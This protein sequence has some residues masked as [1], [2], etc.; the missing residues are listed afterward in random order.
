MPSH[1][2]IP[3]YN[4]KMAK[5]PVK[6]GKIIDL[7]KM[8]QKREDARWSAPPRIET[9][10]SKPQRLRTR[11]RKQ[12]ALMFSV[13]LLLGAG[14]VG[15][16]GLVSHAERLAVTEISV[17]GAQHLPAHALTAAVQ[18]GMTDN[19][20]LLFAKKNI[21]LYP[22]SELE[23]K[24]SSEFPRIQEV[25]ISRP[26]LMAQAVV[27]TV[28]ERQPYATWC[29]A[30][31]CFFMDENGLIFAEASNAQVPSTPYI[32]RKGLLPET[33][34]VGQTFLR[35]RLS[36]I[37][38]FLELVRA[39]G[40]EPQGITVENEKDFSV[41]LAGAFT[42]RVLFDVKGENIIHDLK[43]ALEADSVRERISELEYVDMRFGNRVYYKFI[44][45]PVSEE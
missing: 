27:V 34:I 8:A 13:C 45:S 19:R 21:F 28:H 18:A 44:G 41:P 43:L 39:A 16:L 37:A 5:G 11:R 32:F 35:G 25:R 30:Q 15:G 10:S 36:E 22:K 42:L 17:S 40:Y 9:R 12:R 24:L 4:S 31:Q 23:T 3:R 20:W 38:H 6:R 7:K 29:N 33:E 14:L 2:G 26:S 1:D